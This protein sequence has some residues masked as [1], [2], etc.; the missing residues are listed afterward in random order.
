MHACMEVYIYFHECTYIKYIC[1]HVHV[2]AML[3]CIYIY[4]DMYIP[5]IHLMCLVHY[6]GLPVAS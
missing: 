4:V 6:V 5:Y 1:I 3:M 2:L